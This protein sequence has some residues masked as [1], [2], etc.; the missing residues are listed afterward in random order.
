MS[1]PAR[2]E[3]TRSR[4][5]IGIPH[6]SSAVEEKYLLTG[7]HGAPA[8]LFVS[9]SVPIP[10]VSK[11]ALRI[12]TLNPRRLP[13]LLA[14]KRILA[15][16]CLAFI[17]LYVFLATPRGPSNKGIPVPTSSRGHMVYTDS[18]LKRILEWEVLSGH[19]PSRRQ[20][21]A[22]LGFNSRTPNPALP[23]RRGTLDVNSTTANG[24]GPKRV[25]LDLTKQRP[26]VA[27]PPRPVPGSVVDLDIIH[28]HCDFSDGR[29]VRDCLEVLRIGGGLDNGN[30]YR[31][32]NWDDWKYIYMENE[33]PAPVDASTLQLQEIERT[34]GF[35]TL[36]LPPVQQYRPY[37]TIHSQCD[38]ENPR[39]FH[40]FWGGPINDKPYTTLMSFLYT[41]NVGLN[42]K[43]YPEDAPCRPQFWVWLNQAPASINPPPSALDDMFNDLKA[44][45]WAAPF[46][47]PRFK[48]VI[49]FK[50]WNTTEMLDGVPE[51]KNEWRKMGSLFKSGSDVMHVQEQKA[52]SS[53][54]SSSSSST[55]TAAPPPT[56]GG[57]NKLSTVLSDMA[58][59]ILTHRFGGIY[60]DADQILLRDWE[61]LWGWKGAFAYRW[62]YHNKYN[63]AVLRMHKG[64][65]LG[66][67]LFRTALGNGLDFHPMS[68][69]VYLDQAYFQNLLYRIPDALFD[70]A[71]LNTEG[72]QKERP[73]QPYFESFIHFFRTPVQMSAAPGALGFDGFFRGAYSYH[74]H[75]P[76]KPFDTS[77]NYPD[78]GE[79]F[80]RAVPVDVVEETVAQ[81]RR[82]L[83][84][85]TVM[86]RSFEGFVRGEKPNMYGD[87][88]EW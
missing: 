80:A 39:I 81:D 77:R 15:G 26:D 7:G 51:L 84:W 10:G 85:S 5:T 68:V 82:D 58:R 65:A 48:D 43:D 21:P 12:W 67:F 75:S 46:L 74:Y 34:G 8:P 41:Q 33:G 70:P 6:Y 52:E 2:H 1:F 4:I 47:H 62:S 55:T 63:T 50:L 35:Q 18:D 31:R 66:T 40:M 60:L 45:P 71:W 22:E 88:M 17:L 83:D 37:K 16:F 87:W 20:L 79:H 24:V 14:R 32:G 73:P 49:K 13:P 44:N 72:Y 19:W 76:W 9:Y 3:R 27:Y 54:S 64:S 53:S 25:Y 29:F 57:Y 42:Y 61:D 36:S 56:E 11:R 69:S 38:P 59:F 28:R 86:K 23:S 78:L 30:R